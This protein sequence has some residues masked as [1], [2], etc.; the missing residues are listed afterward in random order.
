MGFLEIGLLVVVLLPVL[1]A[2]FYYNK[3]VGLNNL[4]QEDWKQIEPLLQQRLD[5]IPNLIAVAKGVMKQERALFEGIAK[6]REAALSA[7]SMAD[8]MKANAKVGA[9]LGNLYAREEAYPEMKSNQSLQMAMEGIS[10]IEDKIKYGRQRYQSTVRGYI[11]ATTLFPGSIF[12][13]MFGYKSDKWPYFE[14]EES[15]RKAPDVAVL[16]KD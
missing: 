15:A 14:A 2:V 5:T 10:D 13:G 3:L 16:M 4:A 9:L 6:A 1:L 11:D 7:G 12:A 8:K